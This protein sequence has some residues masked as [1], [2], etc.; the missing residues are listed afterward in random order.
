MR[1]DIRAVNIV[2]YGNNNLILLLLNEDVHVNLDKFLTIIISL[3]ARLTLMQS[4][5]GQKCT[6]TFS[7]ISNEGK[8][9]CFRSLSQDSN[10]NSHNVCSVSSISFQQSQT[11]DDISVKMCFI[12]CLSSVVIIP[13]VCRRDIH[14]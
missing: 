9:Y 1:L 3:C 14:H 7:L 8:I 5:S 12:F 13:Y 6:A 2:C 4:Y 11:V 10:C